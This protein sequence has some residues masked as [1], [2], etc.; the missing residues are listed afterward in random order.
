MVEIPDSLC[1][2]RKGDRAA[3]NESSQELWLHA[4]TLGAPRR[5]L[6]VCWS[7]LLPRRRHLGVG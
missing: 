7:R 5:R 3:V 1:S 2:G 4:S 6:C